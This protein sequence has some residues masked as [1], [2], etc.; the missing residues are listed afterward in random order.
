MTD[1]SERKRN[2][3]E[4]IEAKNKAEESDRLKSAFLANI[5]HEIR[6]PMNSIFGAVSILKEKNLPG[7]ISIMNEAEEQE[8]LEIITN[9]G[10]RMLET[11]KNIIDI[12]RIETKQ[13]EIRTCG[14]NIC[15]EFMSICLKH[16]P[17]IQ[18]K[19]LKFIKK[20]GLTTNELMIKTDKDKIN[21]VFKNLVSNAL[22]FTSEGY[23]EVGCTKQDDN[24][25]FFVKDSEIG[26][27]KDKLKAIF[28][29]F[30][31]ADLKL[32]R[33]HEGAGLGL[34]IAKSYINLLGGKI[35][36]E[37]KKGEGSSFYFT[38]PY[39]KYVNDKKIK[40]VCGPVI[41]ANQKLSFKNGDNV[42]ILLVEDDEISHKLMLKQLK[43]VTNNLISA[44]SGKDAV[45]ICK[46]N[47]EIDIILMD[48]KMPDM[49]GFEATKQIRKFNRSVP[50]IAQTAYA[51]VGDKEKALDMGFDDYLSKP[52]NKDH[53]VKLIK[54]YSKINSF[55]EVKHN[56]PSS[57]SDINSI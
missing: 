13:V 1:I 40:P 51:L 32:T 29:P 52:I 43:K 18:S 24:L 23:I 37:S 31:Q 11:V 25:L 7:N 22:K 3:N 47:S 34:S 44:F 8:F 19:G 26:I 15:H 20:N 2:E 30:V 38:L 57:N 10:N 16:M 45:E 56:M 12:S 36:V 14:I 48:I 55:R 41:K 27:S 46:N 6:T 50:V 35:W 28:N 54:K 53:L 39:I 17:E 42:T 5:S 9:S 49:D 21:T 4:L 33:S